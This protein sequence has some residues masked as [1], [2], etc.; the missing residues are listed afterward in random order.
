MRRL[1]K[2]SKECI[3]HD[4]LCCEDRLNLILSDEDLDG[5]VK[6][7]EDLVVE[8]CEFFKKPYCTVYNKRPLDCK[9]YPVTIDLRCGT[10]VFVIDLKCPAVK[11]GLIDDRFLNYARRLWKSNWP[12]ESW[13]RKNSEDNRNEK[14]YEWITIDE[15]VLY[16]NNLRK[17]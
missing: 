12:S 6:S 8:D 7:S 10:V 11:K 2:L 16:R 5:L 4:G 17:K 13:I 9:V 14:M 3:S 1:S 15:Y